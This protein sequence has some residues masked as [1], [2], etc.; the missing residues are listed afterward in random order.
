MTPMVLIIWDTGIVIVALQN[1][2]EI[3]CVKREKSPF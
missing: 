1:K 2:G 3:V